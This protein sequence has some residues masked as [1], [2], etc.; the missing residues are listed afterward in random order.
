MKQETRKGTGFAFTGTKLVDS[1]V[2]LWSGNWTKTVEN[3]IYMQS[4]KIHLVFFND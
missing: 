2:L 3:L 4:N 1:T